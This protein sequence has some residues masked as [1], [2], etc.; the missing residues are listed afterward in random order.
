MHH[1]WIKPRMQRVQSYVTLPW[2]LPAIPQMVAIQDS[3]S[4]LPR[5]MGKP[6]LLEVCSARLGDISIW[7]GGKASLLTW[8]CWSQVTTESRK[9]V[10]T[11]SPVFHLSTQDRVSVPA[12]H[13]ED[14]CYH[15]HKKW[16]SFGESWSQLTERIYLSSLF[17]ILLLNT[18]SHNMPF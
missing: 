9:C 14:N 17:I 13:A 18:V 11:F 2:L 3:F 5:E 1:F 15:S 6:G 8:S 12:V 4:P 16:A 10:V 7:G